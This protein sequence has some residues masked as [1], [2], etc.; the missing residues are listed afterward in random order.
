MGKHDYGHNKSLPPSFEEAKN[1]RQRARVAG[2]DPNYWYPA[3]MSRDLA[4][5]AVQEVVFWHRSFAVFR[6]Q[7]GVVRCVENRCAHRNLKLTLGQVEG[8]T[9][10]CAYHGWAYD[11]QGCLVDMPHNDF[12]KKLKINLET[13]PVAERYGMVWFFPGDAALSTQRTI[14]E[15]PEV[16][17]SDPWAHGVIDFH[18]KG[19]HSM[20]MDNV[21][22]FTHGYL[23]RKWRPFEGDNL[24]DLEEQED[25]VLLQYDTKIAAAK[26][27][28]VLIDRKAH[29]GTSHYSCYQYPYQWSNTEEFVKHWM[30]LCP[31]DERNT[32]VYFL[33]YYADF[34]VPFMPLKLPRKLMTPLVRMGHE[35]LVRPLFNEDG[36]AV[37]QEQEGYNAH[38]DAPLAEVNPQ[39]L[40]YQRLTVRKWE[41]YLESQNLTTI[42]RNKKSARTEAGAKNR[43]RDTENADA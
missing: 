35:M 14:P 15:I 20:I 10:R 28:D 18:W 7:D 21:S 27:M 13:F 39:V 8:C 30:F 37:Q 29:A 11:G 42:K 26:I 24:L 4:V 16:E 19:H 23:H 40:A 38:W 43:D 33:F 25:R 5:G 9:L 12:G 22:D 2:L 3:L 34:K 17:G 36:W 6:G 31:I 32:K 1:L 41:A